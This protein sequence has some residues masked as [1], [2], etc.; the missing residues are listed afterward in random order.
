MFEYFEGNYAWNLA[1]VTLVEDVGTISEPAEAF[2][3]VKH[4]EGAAPEVANEAWYEAMAKLAG[5]LERMAEEDLSAGHPLTA[6]RKFHRSA[7]YY[8]RA[9]RMMSHSDT[10]RMVAYKR[11]VAN[12]RK[13]RDLEQSDVEFV[14]IPYKSGVLPALLVRA[15][16]DG[17]APIVIHIQGFDSIK[18]TQYPVL[19]EYRRR[20]LSVLIVD[21]PGA[22]GA[23]RLYGLPAE[24]ETENYISKVVDYIQSRPDIATDQI[25]LAGISMG[26]YFAPRAAAFEPRI[27]ACACWGAM[28]SAAAMVKRL[29]SNAVSAAP[30]VPNPTTHGLW[31]W[32][33]ASP[34]ELAETL[35]RMTL[36]G[37]IEKI[38][39]PLLVM[40]GEND[41]Q[42]PLQHA[43]D[44]YERATTPNKTLKIF[45]L[46]GGGAEHCQI[47]NRTLAADCLADWFSDTFKA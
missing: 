44:T 16:S 36:E 5:R 27:K 11:A 42:V 2:Q 38:T 43:L 15:K 22:G 24:I 37:V 30:S 21:Q 32:G 7:M 45:T 25:G 12:Y 28:F 47:D 1:V 23:L 18:E 9:E 31:A 26:G 19:Q 6:A 41:R 13:A 40:H 46:E 33:A 17:P 39:C 10:R 3:A 20:G 29:Q 8:I 35:T 34:Q 14:D 4:L